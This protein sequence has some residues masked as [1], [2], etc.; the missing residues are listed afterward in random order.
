[1]PNKVPFGTRWDMVP[2]VYQPSAGGIDHLCRL[3]VRVPG[4]RARGPG[5][6]PQ[7][8]Q[9]FR[10]T[11]GLER[12]PLNLVRIIGEPLER[13][14][15]LRSRKPRLTTVGNRHVDPTTPLYP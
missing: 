7:R 1:M 4:Y 5:H 15:L 2:V 3:V 6:D 11:V 14:E 13:K 8:C 12:G 10:V 9:L